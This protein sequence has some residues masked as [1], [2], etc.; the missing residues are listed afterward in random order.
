MTPGLRI[1]AKKAGFRRCGIAHPAEPVDHPPGTFTPDEVK[2]LK[3]APQLVVQELAPAEPPAPPPG[4]PGPAEPPPQGDAT[5]EGEADAAAAAPTDPDERL[6]GIKA[7]IG[8][9]DP[10]AA[11]HFTKGGK[12]D[13]NVLSDRLGWR[14]GSAERDAAW[15]AMQPGK[16]T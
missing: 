4:K 14:V 10:E 1:A 13:A 15:A 9:L 6:A 3:D 12:P 7:A 8:A 2:R 5:G 16:N 11:D